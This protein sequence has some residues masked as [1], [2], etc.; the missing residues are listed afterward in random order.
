MD[1]NLKENKAGIAEIIAKYKADVELLIKFLPWLEQKSGEDLFNTYVPEQATAGTMHVPV[2]DSTLLN[3]INT[4]KRT[5]FMNKN[6]VYT[7]SRKRIRSSADERKLI[8][9]AQITDMEMLG[10]ILSYYVLKGMVKSKLWTEGISNG[11]FY[12]LVKKMKELIEF[13]TV[14]M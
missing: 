2:Y 4:A 5:G 1:N 3:F 10:D 6:Y 13:W 11:V 7:Y 12:H 8:Q 9:N 14:P